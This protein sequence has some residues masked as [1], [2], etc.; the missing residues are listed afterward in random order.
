MSETPIIIWP[1]TKIA[2]RD[3]V[4]REAISRHARKL[5][6]LHPETPV[7]LDARGR[8]VG[9]SVAHL[10]E[11][12]S[13]FVNP[14]KA[15]AVVKATDM[16]ASP[17]PAAGDSFEEARRQSEWIRVSRERLRHQEELGQLVRVDKLREALD[18]AGGEIR[19]A[20]GRL[21]A[22]ADD[23]AH[24]VGREGIS[25]VRRKLKEIGLEL[26]NK[27]ADKLGS[28]AAEAPKFDPL[29]ET[30]NS[31]KPKTEGDDEGA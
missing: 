25:G 16:R 4:T 15:S 17:T 6:E 14:A 12:R 23:V 3:G 2:E 29:I 10:D 21:P 19:A 20:W 13:R 8:I 5:L 31:T 11:F 7:E 28:I 30:E 18:S 24:A 27:L 22:Y 1:I 9:I 26:G